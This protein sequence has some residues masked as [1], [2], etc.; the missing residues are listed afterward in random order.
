MA[1]LDQLQRKNNSPWLPF[2]PILFFGIILLSKSDN[3]SYLKGQFNDWLTDEVEIIEDSY[4]NM[5]TYMYNQ[6][7]LG[8]MDYNMTRIYQKE[9]AKHPEYESQLT[10]L[11]NHLAKWYGG[12]FVVFKQRSSTNISAYGIGQHGMPNVDELPFFGECENLSPLGKAMCSE[13]Q[14]QQFIYQHLQQPEGVEASSVSIELVVQ[15][16][17][18]ISEVVAIAGSAVDEKL[19]TAAIRVVQAMPKWK[20]AMKNGEAVPCKLYI[21]ILLGEHISPIMNQEALHLELWTTENIESAP[22]TSWYQER[23]KLEELINLYSLVTFNQARHNYA[24]LFSRA[25]RKSLQQAAGEDWREIQQWVEKITDD[26]S[27]QVNYVEDE[28]GRLIDVLIQVEE[29]AEPSYSDEDEIYAALLHIMDDYETGM[30][31][32]AESAIEQALGEQMWDFI[33]RFPDHINMAQAALQHACNL[34]KVSTHT[35]SIRKEA[36]E[37]RVNLRR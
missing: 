4:A 21:P 9:V 11:A 2:L 5:E 17:G 12:E 32:Q 8:S 23:E 22:M 16:N 33:N 28:Q 3:R 7:E 35:V 6:V 15:A 29:K 14:L 36:A 13:Q 34:K 19:K 24:V 31:E 10:L 20:P 27:I 25:T 18:Q 26:P 37:V 1:L 30:S